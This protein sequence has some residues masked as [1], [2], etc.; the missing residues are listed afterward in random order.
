MLFLPDSPGNHGD[1]EIEYE[2]NIHVCGV[3]LFIKLKTLFFSHWFPNNIFPNNC[4]RQANPVFLILH[5]TCKHFH[6]EYIHSSATNIIKTS[7]RGI[8]TGK[9]SQA[10]TF[11]CSFGKCVHVVVTA[12]R[13]QLI[14]TDSGF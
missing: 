5:L 11:L 8:K 13:S 7:A 10:L 12:G 3:Y 4:F 9:Q 14:N 6:I 1:E 2:K